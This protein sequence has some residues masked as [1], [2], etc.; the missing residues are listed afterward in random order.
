[1]TSR[2]RTLAFFPVLLAAF[3]F[4][5]ALAAAENPRPVI[6]AVPETVD[7]LRALEKQVH[8]LPAK[9]NFSQGAGIWVPYGTATFALFH[10]AKA[11]AGETVLIHGASGG[12]GTAAVQIARAAGMTVIG[13]GGVAIAPGL[14]QRLYA[15]PFVPHRI[16][17]AVGKR[18]Y[19]ASF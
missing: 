8:A 12:V 16:Y 19:V 5:T 1:M 17:A 14:D 11:R 13:T 10:S 6:K 15:D 2:A 18:L 7:D 4:S 3:L 9:I